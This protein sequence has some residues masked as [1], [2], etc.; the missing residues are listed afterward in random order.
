M[1]LSNELLWLCLITL[2]TSVMWL[3]YVINRMAEMG[4]WSA[5]Y[6]PQ[7]DIRPKAQWAER[8]MRAHENAVENLIIFAPLVILIELTQSHSTY[9]ALAVEIYFY[10]R[11]VHFFAFTFAIPLIRV[12][13]FLTGF[14]SQ[15]VLSLSI[16]NMI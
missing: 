14:F 15:L 13:A 1:T 2:F 12:P 9:S 16:L 6:N 5:L 3:P 8:M 7:P 11:L 10:S 4:I